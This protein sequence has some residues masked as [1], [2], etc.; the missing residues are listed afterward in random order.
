MTKKGSDLKEYFESNDLPMKR[1]GIPFNLPD[2]ATEFT[3]RLS[4]IY[5]FYKGGQKKLMGAQA[6]NETLPFG[7][8]EFG[9][10]DHIWIYMRYENDKIDPETGEA[11]KRMDAAPIKMTA[12]ELTALGAVHGVHPSAL[13]V[14]QVLTKQETDKIKTIAAVI[15]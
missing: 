3:A 4:S 6:G 5:K 14:D 12:A 13:T 11:T 1:A 7:M 10:L 9:Q 2:D 15:D 8:A